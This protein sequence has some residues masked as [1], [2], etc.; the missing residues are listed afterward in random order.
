MKRI[1]KIIPGLAI[2][3]VIASLAWVLGQNIKIVGGAVFALIIGMLVRLLW[4]PSLRFTG[5]IKFSSKKVLQ[6]AIILLG[7]EMNIIRVLETGRDSLFVMLFSLAAAFG[8]AYLVG[9]SIKVEAN[10]A[11]LIGVGTA[12]CGGSA[13]AAAAPV[14]GAKDEEIAQS[15]STI[16]LFNI[17]AVFIF[18]AFGRLLGMGDAGFGIWAGTAIND[19]SS[20]LAA[21]SS[22]SDDTLKLAAIVK[23]TRTLMIVPVTFALALIVAKKK[24]TGG[25]AAMSKIFPFFVLGFLAASLIAST[26]IIP[27]AYSNAFVQAG[28]FMIVAAMSAIGLSTNIITLIKNGKRPIILGAVCW[29]AVALSTILALVVIDIW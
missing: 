22:W 7:L 18:P 4:T 14:I 3:I 8:A 24:G 1:T 10:S 20:V 15:I 28:K 11:T 21:A 27:P 5:G 19:T 9:R 23:L 17:I 12:I 6:Y 26:G 2:C 13:I 16:F 29:I 25:K